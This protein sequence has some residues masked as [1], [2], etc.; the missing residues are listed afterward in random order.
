MVSVPEFSTWNLNKVVAGVTTFVGNF[1]LAGTTGK[2]AALYAAGT[3]F[4]MTIDDLDAVSYSITDSALQTGTKAGLWQDVSE[5][6]TS[7]TFD[8]ASIKALV[9]GATGA[10][11]A[12]GPQGA[13]GTSVTA[14]SSSLTADVTMTTAGTWYNGPSVTL[15]SGTYLIIGQATV[16]SPTNTAHRFTSRISNESTTYYVEAQQS[17]AAAGGS[18]RAT[19]TATM[20]TTVT[21]GAQTN[22]RIEATSTQNTCLLKAEATDNSSLADRATSIIAVK[23]A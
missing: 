15:Q 10:Q 3:T 21:L 18:V 16:A 14:S 7:F 4:T 1:G 23:I 19:A 2:V 5:T 6:G 9:T 11:G 22:L 20:V 8:N 17:T 13:A 12:Q